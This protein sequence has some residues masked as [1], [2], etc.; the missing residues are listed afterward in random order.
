MSFLPWALRPCRTLLTSPTLVSLAQVFHIEATGEVFRS[1][2]AFLR[3]KELYGQVGAAQRALPP[4]CTPP[5]REPVVWG[6]V[7]AGRPASLHL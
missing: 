1:Y 7:S 6:R 3:Q 2:E 5:R 4:V